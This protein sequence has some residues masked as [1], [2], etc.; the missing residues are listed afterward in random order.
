MKISKKHPDVVQEN[1]QKPLKSQ[2]HDANLKLNSTVYFQVGLIVCLLISYFLLETSFQSS[3]VTIPSLPELPVDELYAYNVPIR[4]YEEPAK[5]E[6]KKKQPVVF[7]N[8]TISDDDVVFETP[9]VVTEPT[10]SEPPLDPG[11]IN[12]TNVPEDVPLMNIMAVEQVPI[13]P[14]CEEATSNEARRECMSEKIARHI[15]KK[16]NTNIAGDLG[17]VGDQKIYVTFKIDATG[18]I[19]NI[20]TSS[21]HIQL[22]KES[23]RVLEKLPQMT[24]A[25]QKDKNVEVL[26]GLP[27]KFHIIN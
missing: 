11:S 19:T 26:Y 6:K 3:E 21:K 4:I 20:K 14:G 5:V 10:I 1:K 7:N 27:I 8:P 17:L 22:D 12:V 13:F 9:D 15:Q 18:H 16:F 24:P 25:K 23:E 2:K